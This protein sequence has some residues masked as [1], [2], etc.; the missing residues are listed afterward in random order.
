MKKCFFRQAWNQTII[1]IASWIW[2]FEEL[3]FS[4]L[5][6]TDWYKMWQKNYTNK[7]DV[8]FLVHVFH[9]DITETF[10]GRSRKLKKYWAYNICV[11]HSSRVFFMN[12]FVC[13]IILQVAFG[14]V[15]KMQFFQTCSKVESTHVIWGADHFWIRLSM[16]LDARFWR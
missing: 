1:C 7:G 5:P 9:Y 13:I 2:Y 15:R 12:S 14:T 8:Q 16:S 4:W 10:Q 6:S 3:L 11:K